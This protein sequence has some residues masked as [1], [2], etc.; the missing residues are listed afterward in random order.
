MEANSLSFLNFSVIIFASTKVILFGWFIVSTFEIQP[1]RICF[2]QLLSCLNTYFLILMFF[3]QLIVMILYLGKPYSRYFFT[4][5]IDAF[6]LLFPNFICTFFL[7]SHINYSFFEKSLVSLLFY[8]PNHY[9]FTHDFFYET[10]LPTLSRAYESLFICS[11]V[12]VQ[13]RKTHLDII[14]TNVYWN[15]KSKKNPKSLIHT[16]I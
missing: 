4:L 1:P 16:C 14:E 12:L 15:V 13:L 3:K 7:L 9:F 8:I 2:S 6:P 10:F 11:L 5:I